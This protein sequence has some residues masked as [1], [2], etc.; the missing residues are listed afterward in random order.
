MTEPEDEGPPVES[1]DS[2]EIP[3]LSINV[4]TVTEDLLE[5]LGVDGAG[6]VIT[7]VDTAGPAADAGLRRGMVISRVGNTDVANIGELKQ[8]LS[9]VRAGGK[10]LLLVRFNQGAA[11]VVRFVAVRVNNLE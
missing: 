8:A 1:T 6:V 2:S 11:N 10:A 3:E 5:P 7:S 4:Q 9:S